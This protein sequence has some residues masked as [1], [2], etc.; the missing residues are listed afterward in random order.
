[1]LDLLN[2]AAAAAAAIAVPWENSGGSEVLAT[3]PLRGFSVGSDER[4]RSGSVKSMS[5]LGERSRSGSAGAGYSLDTQAYFMCPGRCQR[6]LLAEHP[7]YAPIQQKQ[8]EQR[9]ATIDIE[10]SQP[11]H[12]GS[13]PCGALVCIGCR[14]L[15]DPTDTQTHVCSTGKLRDGVSTNGIN[16]VLAQSGGIHMQ[17]HATKG[18]GE[19]VVRIDKRC[20]ACGVVIANSSNS[21]VVM[22]GNP[23]D[24]HGAVAVALR[25]G[26]CAYIF[27]WS[28]LEGVVGAHGYIGVDGVQV[29][30]GAPKTDRQVLLQA[31]EDTENDLL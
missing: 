20:P 6:A 21:E 14:A 22:C 24:P 29:A 23:D 28:S 3:R 10:L 25:E 5:D 2:H 1:L 19:L 11:D 31:Q 8:Q 17:A 15:F 12:L 18:A 4:S 30:A 27:K 26:G 16:L 7:S 9:L 13:C